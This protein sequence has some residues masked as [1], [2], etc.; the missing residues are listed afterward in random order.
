[1][2]GSYDQYQQIKAHGEWDG[3][4]WIY[5]KLEAVPDFTRGD[6]RLA[7]EVLDA[8]IQGQDVPTYAH[9]RVSRIIPV[10]ARG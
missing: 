1:M 3:A 7:A 2:R 9:E 6:V 10:L 8:L 4:R 5:P